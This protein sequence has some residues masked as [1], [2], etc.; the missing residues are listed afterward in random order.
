[1]SELEFSASEAAAAT[2]VEAAAVA[3]QPVEQNAPEVDNK[4][5]AD[6]LADMIAVQQMYD[7]EADRM[8][9]GNE[10]LRIRSRMYFGT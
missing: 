3:P 7:L 10:E 9:N 2:E 8:R 6:Q 1:M 5:L 4:S